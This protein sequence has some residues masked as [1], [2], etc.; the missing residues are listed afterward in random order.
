ME[1]LAACFFICGHPEWAHQILAPFSYGEAFL[2]INSTIFEQYSSCTDEEAIKATE[3]AWLHKIEQ[4]YTS[5]RATKD[6]NQDQIWGMGNINH[7]MSND[8]TSGTSGSNGEESEDHDDSGH[9]PRD[10]PPISDDEEEMAELRKKVLQSKRFTETINLDIAA[11][12]LEANTTKS[13]NVEN[14]DS[15]QG[16]SADEDNDD[17]D[18]IINAT[19]ITDRTGI[20]AK[21]NNATPDKL[22]ST[23]TRTVISAPAKP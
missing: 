18:K 14:R 20:V 13:L 3:S 12:S 7:R 4:E 10:L 5:S 19:P 11:Q 22:T 23:F 9:F 1:A 16:S 8:R 6:L 2:E 17:F 21:R 15:S